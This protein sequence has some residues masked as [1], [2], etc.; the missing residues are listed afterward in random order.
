M[1]RYIGP[2]CKLAR[3]E[4]TDLFLKSPVRTID[5]KC[6]FDRAP[7]VKPGGRRPRT[8]VYG[9]QLREKQKLRRMYGVL[10]KQFRAYYAE[11]ARLSG[12]TGLNLLQLLE[13][14]LDNVVYRMGFGVTRA[15]CRQLVSHKSVM[16]NGKKVNI[17][18]YNVKAGDVIEIT[19]KSKKQ[20]R[21]TS[22]MEIAE[23][24]GIV[25]WVEVDVKAVK[26]VFK[27]LPDRAD[28]PPD[29]NEA[30]VVALYSK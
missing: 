11:A 12:S 3:R 13:S 27:S 26:G 18:S 6:K 17:A 1:A 19:E 30:L 7:G 5:S 23:Q 9:T 29:I 10:E 2:T 15:E 24:I 20:L 16:V 8:T 22:A 4:G 25:P 14:R 21:I 28:L